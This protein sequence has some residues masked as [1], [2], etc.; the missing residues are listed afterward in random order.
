MFLTKVFSLCTVRAFSVSR[1][2]GG[3][4]VK[5]NAELKFSGS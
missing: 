1:G 4:L 3:L 2:F 5:N